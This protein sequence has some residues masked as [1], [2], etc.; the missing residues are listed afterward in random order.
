[1]R[2]FC[3]SLIRSVLIRRYR[4]KDVFIS[5]RKSM[6]LRIYLQSKSKRAKTIALLDSGATENFMSLDYAKHLHLPIK[7]L[8]EPRK[9]FNVDRTPNKARD[10]KF[11][12]NLRT[13]TE[14]NTRTLHYFLSNLGDSRVILGY[15]W[16]A[17]AQPKINWARGWIA[18]DQLP[19]VLCAVDA[20]KA[21]FLPRQ[22]MAQQ[23]IVTTRKPPPRWLDNVQLPYRDYRNMFEQRKGKGLPPSQPWDHAIDLKP[24]APTTLISKTICLSQTK[25]RELSQFLKEHTKR[26][27]I[28][29]LKSPYAALFFFIKKKNGKLR[30]VQDYRPVNSWTIKNCYPLPLIPSLIDRLQDCSLFTGFNIKWG[31]NKVLIKPEDQWKA[32][33]ITNKGLYEPT[34]MFFGLTNSPATFQTIMNT[35]F[36]NL[37]DEGS[38]TIY[39]DDIAI[40]MGTQPGESD[41]DHLKHHRILVR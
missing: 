30:P 15:P 7:T 4:D 28:Q 40:H 9:L 33:F 19:I 21:Q 13:R 22:A 20:A 10:L 35:I 23:G 27:T 14:T 39:M 2:G 26:G 29:P 3:R 24:R 6:M 32:A 37:I 36:R 11:Y 18:Y 16:F 38:V 34:V 5:A 8:R 31:Y 25:Q 41:E 1:M 12:T 17:A